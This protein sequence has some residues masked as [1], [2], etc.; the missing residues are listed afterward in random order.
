MNS[1]NRKPKGVRT[2]GEVGGAVSISGVD[3][4]R[5]GRGHLQVD[6]LPSVLQGRHGV[7][8]EHVLQRHMV[9]LPGSKV[10]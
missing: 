10:R 1:R 5:V 8:M 4:L 7:F 2:A 6:H 3:I 9:H